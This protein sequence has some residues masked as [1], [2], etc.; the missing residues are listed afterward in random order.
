MSE[1]A[2]K[3]KEASELEAALSSEPPLITGASR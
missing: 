2:S 1:P 3:T